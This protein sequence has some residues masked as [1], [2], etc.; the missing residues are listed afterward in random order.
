MRVIMAG[1]LQLFQLPSAITTME[2]GVEK[3]I[4]GK[5]E[6]ESN[7]EMHRKLAEMPMTGPT[8]VPGLGSCRYKLGHWFLFGDHIYCDHRRGKYT[9]IYIDMYMF[10]GSGVMAD[11]L[12]SVAM[13]LAICT[14]QWPSLEYC[15]VFL[16]SP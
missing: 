14:L 11:F 1:G 13:L 5:A 4:R 15:S 12:H 9:Y 3:E 7:E 16:R 10:V 2:E 8:D 6:S